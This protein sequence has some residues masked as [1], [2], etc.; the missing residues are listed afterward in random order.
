MSNPVFNRIDKQ[1]SQSGP[2]GYAGFDRQAASSRS[3]MGAGAQDSLNSQQL[4]DLYNQP[5]AGSVQR[6]QVTLD[7]VVMK[8]LGLFSIVLLVGAG[9]WFVVSGNEKLSL[10]LLLA[11]M[12]GSLAV[13]LAIAF[14]KTI[15]VPLIV[16]YSVLEGVL[17]GAISS[18]FESR[19][20]GIVSTAVIA[21]ASTFAGMF[22]A[23]RFG[24]IKVTDKSRRIFGMALMGYVLFG[25]VNVIASFMGVGDNWGFG[26]KNGRLG[27][28]ISVLGVG[29]A[30]YS[31]AID[32]DSVDRA[33]AAKM[34]EKYSWLLA[35]GLIV[36]LVWLYLEILRLLARL[37]E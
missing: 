36:T 23:W 15:S 21:T 22:L 27:I 8:T 26:G 14:K 1:V 19:Y 3:G 29:L 35:H 5:S 4:Q 17:V 12:F 37:R 16:L 33:V 7:D 11:G 13:G 10:P 6:G 20:P 24:I 34:P 25:L 31:L 30:S 32:F 28:G 2:G 9:S 18:V